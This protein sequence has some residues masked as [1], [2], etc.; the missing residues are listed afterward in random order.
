MTHCRHTT[1]EVWAAYSKLMATYIEQLDHYTLN[2]NASE[3]AWPIVR[4]YTL[5]LEKLKH[6][7]WQA[8]SFLLLHNTFEVWEKIPVSVWLA[9]QQ[10]QWNPTGLYQWSLNNG[11]IQQTTLNTRSAGQFHAEPLHI[12]MGAGILEQCFKELPL[13][14]DSSVHW[15]LWDVFY[16]EQVYQTSK[17]LQRRIEL[18]ALATPGCFEHAITEFYQLAPGMWTQASCTYILNMDMA[19]GHSLTTC[20]GVLLLYA[21]FQFRGRKAFSSI[22]KRYPTLLAGL[23]L[24]LALYPDIDT[25]LLY[26]P[27]L[28]EHW[29]RAVYGKGTDDTLCLPENMDS[30]V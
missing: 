8:Y 2:T 18:L 4:Y 3:N 15:N 28:L 13:L 9:L 25:A 22:E 30:G 29:R 1:P 14:L 5:A 26:A 12:R 17:D 7:P 6:G 21:R 27:A 11:S 24:H 19:Q 23:D 20:S 16:G 10:Q